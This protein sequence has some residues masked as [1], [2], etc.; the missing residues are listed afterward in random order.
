MCVKEGLIAMRILEYE[1]INIE[2]TCYLQRNHHIK[3]KIVFNVWLQATIYQQQG[4]I[5]YG[6]K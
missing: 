4:N 6:I 3:K 2:T 1:N 5:F